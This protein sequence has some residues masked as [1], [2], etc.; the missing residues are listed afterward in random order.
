MLE[1][2]PETEEQVGTNYYYGFLTLLSSSPANDE[3]NF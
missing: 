2:S 3:H 1:R